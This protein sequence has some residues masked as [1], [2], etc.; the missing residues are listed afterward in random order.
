MQA[1]QP[2]YAFTLKESISFLYI[3]ESACMLFTIVFWQ[4][5]NWDATPAN[6]TAM[7]CNCLTYPEP[8]LSEVPTLV[9]ALV[10]LDTNS[11][12]DRSKALTR[13]LVLLRSEAIKI[14]TSSWVSLALF[15]TR[16]TSE[17][18]LSVIILICS[19]ALASLE[20]AGARVPSVHL[21]HWSNWASNLAVASSI[22][23]EPREAKL[24]KA[25]IMS[26]KVAPA[27]FAESMI[28]LIEAAAAIAELKM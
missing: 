14:C 24:L 27:L 15:R 4:V 16:V 13:S 9:E 5:V 11:C 25:V 22:A 8:P 3:C 19:S 2:A 20:R 21:F 6:C 23:W 28:A 7:S 1:T 12:S 26:L 18:T 10:M 17:V